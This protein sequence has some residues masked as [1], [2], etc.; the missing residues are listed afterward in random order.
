MDY[1]IISQYLDDSEAVSLRDRL[2]AAGIPSIIT[3]HG[4]GGQFRGGFYN[5]VKIN[6]SD[7][8][9]ALP[10]VSKFNEEI[11]TDRIS[12]KHELTLKCPKCDSRSIFL[13]EKKSI[14]DKVFYFGV[15]VWR[16]NKCGNEW[17][18]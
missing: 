9:K 15:T 11:E 16:C 14:F 18:T 7:F 1:Y 4:P 2:L 6:K 12:K 13:H 3:P 5:L 8:E 17:Y 10:I